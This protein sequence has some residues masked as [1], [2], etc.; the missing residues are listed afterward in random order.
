MTRATDVATHDAGERRRGAR[1]PANGDD[2]SAD[3]SMLATTTRVPTTASRPRRLR[4][5]GHRLLDRIRRPDRRP[6]VVRRGRDLERNVVDRCRAV[7]RRE[8]RWW[9]GARQRSRAGRVR[10]RDCGSSVGSDRSGF[11]RPG[12]GRP[13]WSAAERRSRPARPPRSP[14]RRLREPAAADITTGAVTDTATDAST[15]AS[16]GGVLVPDIVNG[17]LA[18]DAPS[19]RPRR[20]WCAR[21]RPSPRSPRWCS[22]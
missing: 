15:D 2:G 1:P 19:A 4:D 16:T 22:P 18:H 20:S 9:H 3:E 11:G 5:G 17:A 6:A 7:Q 12:R 14:S 8:R 10:P 21:R 13:G